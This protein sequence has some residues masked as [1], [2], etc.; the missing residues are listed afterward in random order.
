MV[1]YSLSSSR[2]ASSEPSLVSLF[3][4]V[5][6]PGME[7]Q[8]SELTDSLTSLA[9]TTWLLLLLSASS[10][11]SSVTWVNQDQLWS[12]SSSSQAGARSLGIRSPDL[13]SWTHPGSP[14]TLFKVSNNILVKYWWCLYWKQHLI[15]QLN[16]LLVVLQTYI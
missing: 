2:P 11:I 3:S 12:W 8:Q 13:V 7:Q 9:T 16:W 4:G 6:S 10:V 5:T 15:T 14:P 1:F